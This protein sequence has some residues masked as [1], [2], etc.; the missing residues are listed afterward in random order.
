MFCG[1]CGTRLDTQYCPQDGWSSEGRRVTAAEAPAKPPVLPNPVVTLGP[2]SPGTVVTHGSQSPGVVNGPVNYGKGE[3]QAPQAVRQDA[4]PWGKTWPLRVVAALA[5]GASVAQITGLDLGKLEFE[6]IA[7]PIVTIFRDGFDFSTPPPA[8]SSPAAFAVYPRFVFS[9]TLFLSIIL[10][11]STLKRRGYIWGGRGRIFE[12]RQR[13]LMRT[14]VVGTCPHNHCGGGLTLKRV[15]VETKSEIT[16]D[17]QGRP[18]Q[19]V[20]DVRGIRLVCKKN[21]EHRFLFDP[22]N[23]HDASVVSR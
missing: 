12:I 3:D 11:L 9:L 1:D 20:R 7:S 14:R 16:T 15:T 6:G 22:T 18:R 21:F 23:L 2:G 13:R 5:A 17:S 10:M 19:K 4:H 8:A